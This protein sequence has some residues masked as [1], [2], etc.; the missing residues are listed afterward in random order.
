LFTAPTKLGKVTAFSR[1]LTARLITPS[2]GLETMYQ[3]NCPSDTL[4]Q[5]CIIPKNEY[6]P[7]SNRRVDTE[8]C[9]VQWA[10]WLATAVRSWL[11]S[12]SLFLPQIHNLETN[13]MGTLIF[14]GSTSKQIVSISK[15][16]LI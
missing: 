10:T 2:L 5:S 12:F 13:L 16:A 1:S 3:K 8:K 6:H 7:K 15:G 9:W 11:A 4:T 14:K